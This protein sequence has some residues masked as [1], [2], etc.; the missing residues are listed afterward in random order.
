MMPLIE[1]ILL[2]HLFLVVT[3]RNLLG[4]CASTCCWVADPSQKG[5][6]Q[7]ERTKRLSDNTVTTIRLRF[8]LGAK[9]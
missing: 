1:T 9:Q 2:A 5:T 8:S 7:I 4:Q 3:S 6:D